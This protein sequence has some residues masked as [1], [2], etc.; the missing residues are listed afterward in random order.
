MKIWYPG[1]PEY[2]NLVGFGRIS[3]FPTKFRK[4][5]EKKIFRSRALN[6]GTKGLECK[7]SQAALLLFYWFPSI[8][9]PKKNFQK[10]RNFD[11][12]IF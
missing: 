5:Y 8:F 6:F 3:N 12:K 4:I 10:F 11:P 2:L 7:V 1:N 9:R